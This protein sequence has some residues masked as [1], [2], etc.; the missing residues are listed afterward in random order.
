MVFLSECLFLH[1][2]IGFRTKPFL[3]AEVHIVLEMLC[4][5]G[6][7]PPN[8]LHW[9]LWGGGGGGGGGNYQFL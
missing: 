7:I 9:L 2:V 1:R 3:S 8:Q 4:L 6:G 5:A